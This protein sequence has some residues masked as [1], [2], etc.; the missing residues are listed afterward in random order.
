MK[1]LHVIQAAKLFAKKIR[2]LPMCAKRVNLTQ[3]TIFHI[4]LARM[5]GLLHEYVAQTGPVTQL[6]SL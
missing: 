5:H 6:Q 4:M 1:L 2:H 3:L